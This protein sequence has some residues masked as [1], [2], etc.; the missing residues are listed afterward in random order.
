MNKIKWIVIEEDPKPDN[1]IPIMVADELRILKAQGRPCSI[2]TNNKDA[3]ERAQQLRT[4]F[5]AKYIRIFHID[6]HSQ[7]I[8]G[9]GL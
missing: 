6:G 9:G 3:I 2:F 5:G 1:Y 4:I 7:N 8:Y